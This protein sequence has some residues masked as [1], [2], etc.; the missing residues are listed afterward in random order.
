MNTIELTKSR[1]IESV[2]YA[3]T[4]APATHFRF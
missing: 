1:L 3:A 2:R 4:V